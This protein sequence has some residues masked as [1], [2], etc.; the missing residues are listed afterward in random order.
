[1]NGLS[2]MFDN[3][4]IVNGALGS[5]LGCIIL[6]LLAWLLRRLVRAAPWIWKIRQGRL[7]RIGARYQRLIDSL[8][9][10]RDARPKVYFD[11]LACFIL[12]CTSLVIL[13][14]AYVVSFSSDLLEAPLEAAIVSTVMCVVAMSFAIFAC[15][16][17]Y[18]DLSA[19]EI[20]KK[21][22][23]GLADNGNETNP[24]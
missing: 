19:I 12:F 3:Q 9:D 20:A 21:R 2:E 7:G 10:D 23:I 16:G 22:E 6:G 17:A 18:L 1:M 14:I 5:I 15:G 11:L 13:A 4:Q 8:V 24:A